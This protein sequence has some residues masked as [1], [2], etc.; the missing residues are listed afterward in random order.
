MCKC[1]MR[2]DLPTKDIDTREQLFV[3]YK[4]LVLQHE[5]NLHRRGHTRCRSSVNK[6]YVWFKRTSLRRYSIIQFTPVT[7]LLPWVNSGV[8]SRLD[9]REIELYKLIGHFPNRR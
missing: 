3:P 1:Y 7:L 8:F 2:A 6:F 9:S 5:L 4:R